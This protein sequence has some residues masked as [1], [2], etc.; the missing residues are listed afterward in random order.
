MTK[1]AEIK[2]YAHT[3][4]EYIKNYREVCRE[5]GGDEERI[6]TTPLQNDI[7]HLVSMLDELE[8][9]PKAHWEKTDLSDE[10]YADIE[11]CTN[12]SYETLEKG[13]FCAN[14]GA[15]MNDELKENKDESSN[16]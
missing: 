9:R 4:A 14:C 7:E 6:P 10:L 8:E 5:Q 3:I 2:E 15:R 1:V 16:S 11:R 12:C 13:N